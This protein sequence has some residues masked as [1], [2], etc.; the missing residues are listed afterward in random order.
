MMNKGE[1]EAEAALSHLTIHIIVHKHSKLKKLV[2]GWDIFLIK[3]P[4]NSWLKEGE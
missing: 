4:N 2:F 1:I 3:L